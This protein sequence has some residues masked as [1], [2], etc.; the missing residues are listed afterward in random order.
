M[1]VARFAGVESGKREK[2]KVKK[3]K[4]YVQ[5]LSKVSEWLSKMKKRISL[6]LANSQVSPATA[7]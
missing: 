6:C 4:R 5:P 3:T 7:G 2:L 1:G